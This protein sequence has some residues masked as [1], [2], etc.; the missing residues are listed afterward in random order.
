MREQTPHEAAAPAPATS[1]VTPAVLLQDVS[2]A[3]ENC[4][5]VL[6]DISLSVAQGDFLALLGPNG[7]G[8]TTLLRILLGILAPS[9]GTAR[10]FG[11]SPASASGHIGY[12][13]QFSTMAKDFPCTVLDMV[14]MGAARP[15]WRGAF[16]P[17]DKKAK[18]KA[19]AYLA[20]LG[21]EKVLHRSVCDLSGGQRQRALVARALMSFPAVF[22]CEPQTSVPLP[23]LLLLDEP[24]ASVDPEGTFCFY[25][26]L[27]KLK[28]C[29]SI[30]VVSHDLFIA[31]PFFSR[32]AF[33]NKTLSTLDDTEISPENLTHLFGRHLHDCPVADMQHAGQAI[34]PDGCSHPACASRA[35]S[36]AE[37]FFGSNNSREQVL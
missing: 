28:G 18:D 35:P 4:E 26:F 27:G 33:V 25:E 29:V 30:I 36:T 11:Q 14:L 2:F 32:V 7:G 17:T 10:I 20:L 34:H 13:P 5:P 1:P 15:G 24:T 6:K 23:Y 19:T 16:W 37:D 12:V 9:T 31:S 8:K 21:M 22:P 3:Y